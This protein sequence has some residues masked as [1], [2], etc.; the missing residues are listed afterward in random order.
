MR[1]SQLAE[2]TGVPATTLRFYETAGLLP[3]GRSRS[4]YRLYGQESIERLAF[5]R[6]AK[7]LGLPLEEIAGLL[8]VWSSGSCADVKAGLRPRVAD[9]LAETDAR[10]GELTAFAASLRRAL[11]HLDALPDRSG[12]CDPHCGFPGPANGPSQPPPYAGGQRWREAPV[13]CSLTGGAMADRARR[14]RGLLDGAGRREIDEGVRLTLPADRAAALTAL[15]ADEQR[16]CPFF[17]FRLHLD[18]P[19]VH[20]EVRAPADGTALLTE[21]FSHS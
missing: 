12:R 14:W 13:A 15:A 16:C 18:G 11:A 6:A 19:V 21:L 10:V 20:L 8:R 17:D 5:I 4:G 7:H 9:R 2:R 1:I 3:A